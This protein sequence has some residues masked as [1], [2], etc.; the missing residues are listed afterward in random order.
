[1]VKIDIQIEIKGPWCT[2]V[3][4]QQNIL[5]KIKERKKKD[6]QRLITMSLVRQLELKVEEKKDID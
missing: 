3:T 2:I 5:Q 1:M 6:C 4:K